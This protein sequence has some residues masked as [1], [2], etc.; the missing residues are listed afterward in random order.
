MKYAEIMKSYLPQYY[1]GF[2][3]MDQ[4]LEVEGAEFDQLLFAIYD[5]LEQWFID[6]AT[7]GLARLEKAHGII[8][9]ETKPI[10][11]RRAYLKS[12]KRGV[13]TV[14]LALIRNVAESFENGTVAV[15]AD[16]S[17]YQVFVR[18]IDTV[19][20]PH[21]LGDIKKAIGDVIPAHLA[22]EFLF[23]YLLIKEVESMK[24]SQLENTSLDQFAF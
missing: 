16:Y 9:D 12:K 19:G 2:K 4:V 13:G 22:V 11:Q 15:T 17:L 1:E 24:L 6:T 5:V 18:F 3:D 21:N 7:W 14:N 10:D 20:R 23:R 8:P